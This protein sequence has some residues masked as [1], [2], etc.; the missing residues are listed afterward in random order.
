MLYNPSLNGSMNFVPG[1]I[2]LIMMIV[3]TS[4]TAVSVVREKEMGT[5]EVLL[6]SPLKPILVLISKAVPYAVLSL[7]NL[8]LILLLSNLVLDVPIRGSIMLLL[9]EC[10]FVHSGL[11]GSWVDDFKRSYIAGYRHAYFDG[12]NISAHIT[13]DRIFIPV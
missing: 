10:F 11:S 4:L 5:M 3:C 6:V 7:V 1:V 13:S 2:A 12:R 9:F 8:S